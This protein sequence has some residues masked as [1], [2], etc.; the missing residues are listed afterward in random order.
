MMI[1]PWDQLH[2]A[3][4]Q[5]PIALLPC[6]VA[7]E[8]GAIGFKRR[9]WARELRTA[10]FYGLTLAAVASLGAATSGIALSGGEPWGR[11]V[12]L[13]QHRLAWPAFVLLVVWAVW[14]QLRREATPPTGWRL[15]LSLTALSSGLVAVA[16]CCAEALLARAG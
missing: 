1:I 2:G 8:F 4:A 6:S 5:F 10:G 9:P 3:M 13:W 11:G 16:A 7:C 12:L 14:R 15:F